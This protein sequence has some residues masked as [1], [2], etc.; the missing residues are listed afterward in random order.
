MMHAI[1]RATQI[2]L[3]AL[4][5]AVVLGCSSEPPAAGGIAVV[6]QDGTSTSAQFRQAASV[7][8]DREGEFSV[9]LNPAALLQTRVG[10]RLNLDLPGKG[11]LALTVLESRELLAGVRSLHARSTA[12]DDTAD[13]DLHLSVSERAMHGN[14]KT[15]QG[16]WLIETR[17]RELRLLDLAAKRWSYQPQ[18]HNDGLPVPG[19][20]AANR[21]STAAATPTPADLPI[22]DVSNLMRPAADASSQT[23]DL[24]VVADQ[25]LINAHGGTDGAQVAIA[26]FVAMTNQALS[27]SAVQA[28]VRLVGTQ[29]LTGN[30]V[31][32]DLPTVWV[33]LL[34]GKAPYQDIWQQ[35]LLTG[36]DMVLLYL[37]FRAIDSSMGYCGVSNW[38]SFSRTSGTYSSSRAPFVIATGIKTDTSS[39]VCASY[40]PAHEIGH[41]LG[42]AHDRASSLNNLS[43]AYTYSY[44]FGIA[45]VFGD[46][47]SLVEPRIGLFANPNVRYKGLA[48]GRFDTIANSADVAKTFNN[49]APLVAQFMDPQARL[50]GWY[51]N[52]AEGGTGW[53]VDVR[54]GRSYVGY[55]H[56]NDDGSPTWVAGNGVDCSSGGVTRQCV[57]LQ[58]FS[59]GQ[60]LVGAFKAVGPGVDVADLT[61][62]FSDT[63]PPTAQ[64]T[65]SGGGKSRTVSLQRF[66]FNANSAIG[67]QAQFPYPSMPQWR[68]DPTQPGTGVF[69]E[70]QG[71]DVFA[72][73]FFY[74][75]TGKPTW[76]VVQGEARWSEYTVVGNVTYPISHGNSE[77]PLVAYQG[78]QTLFGTY[79]APLI[80]N[81]TP[82]YT[83]ILQP[84]SDIVT[85]MSPSTSR[86]STR[87]V[88]YDF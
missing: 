38:G 48:T 66:A 64:A 27:A 73:A 83:A 5:A 13:A 55:F 50:S 1:Q 85:F 14:L 45:G 87:F 80:K 77:L 10:D 49:T 9:Q 23:L 43:G 17:G 25:G 37:P 31:T 88:R 84:E 2:C 4:S 68:W 82:K 6:S 59:G 21:L 78:G 70:Y 79:S 11:T 20:A 12:G 26:N 65:L 86:T 81:Q 69:M 16:D 63:F 52:P 75:S 34:A 22:V 56:Y 40:T 39:A 47:M 15:A 3:A 61:L 60:T 41:L 54:N 67:R 29:Y 8:A 57:K 44:G 33:D 35:R 32:A 76:Q 62:S 28:Q 74:D 71:T 58:S 53:A 51:W 19:E 46:I 36:A 7:A 72:A 42:A 24:L 30:E 18:H